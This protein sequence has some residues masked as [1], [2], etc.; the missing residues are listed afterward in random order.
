MLQCTSLSLVIQVPRHVVLTSELIVAV[1]AEVLLL[2]DDVVVV[3]YV[4]LWVNGLV[5]FKTVGLRPGF[6]FWRGWL[7]PS[8]AMISLISAL[9]FSM[10]IYN[11]IDFKIY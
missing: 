10:S 2:L 7:C 4:V 5:V 6:F 8:T 11:S 3:I 9:E 1:G